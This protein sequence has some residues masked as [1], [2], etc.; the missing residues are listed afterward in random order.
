MVCKPDVCV[1]TETLSD[2]VLPPQFNGY[3]GYHLF[4]QNRK[5]G[6]V[7]IYCRDNV[8]FQGVSH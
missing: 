7:S 1:F 3:V 2:K 8:K 5:D 4:R 6:G